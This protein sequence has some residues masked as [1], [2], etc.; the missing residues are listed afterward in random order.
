MFKTET[1]D[2]ESVL[3]FNDQ[4]VEAF[5]TDDASA[6]EDF[7][8]LMVE[9]HAE[10]ETILEDRDITIIY[11]GDDPNIIIGTVMVNG[12]PAAVC[13]MKLFFE[14]L[15]EDM[16]YDEAHEYFYYNTIGGYMA[17]GDYADWIFVN[18]LED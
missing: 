16:S 17:T 10:L 8:P 12:L 1:E 6:Y 9:T 5:Q 15:Q 18:D 7:Q 11:P 4:L 14:N 3:Y 13:S 2:G